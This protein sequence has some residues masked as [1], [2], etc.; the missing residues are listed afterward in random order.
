MPI[1]IK[2]L[3]IRTVV[4]STGVQPSADSDVAASGQPKQD[5]P[6]MQDVVEECVRQVMRILQRRQER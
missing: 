6:A 2:E 1:E 5:A 4:E 3:V